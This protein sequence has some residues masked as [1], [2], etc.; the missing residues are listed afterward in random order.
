M[1]PIIGITAEPKQDP[2]DARTRGSIVL[3]WNYAQAVADAGGVPLIVPPMA[4]MREVADLIDGWL[5]PGGADIDACR[6][7]QENHPKAEL[8]DPSRFAGEKALFESVPENMPVL[9]ICYGCQFINVIR[10]GDLIQHLPDVEGTTKHTGGEVQS[11]RLDEGSQLS[12]LFE[13]EEVAGKS[14]HHQAVDRAGEGLKV[15]ARNEDG[16]VEAIE[17]TDRPWLI[18]VQWHPERTLEDE[19]MRKLFE[20]F[21]SAA[22]EYAKNKARPIPA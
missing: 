22:R 15:V 8:Q 4:D 19:A 13:S 20:A 17:A 18:G 9:G 6:F 10:G 7:G 12:Q 11:Y 14:Y 5:I 21:V 1:K 3:N 2:E 16:T